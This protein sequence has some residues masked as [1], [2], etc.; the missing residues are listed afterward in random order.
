VS[1]Y[2][3]RG[4]V[5]RTYRLGEADRIVVFLTE[6]HGKARAVAKGVR[7]T[8]SK[9][10]A[11]LEPLTH[12][13]LLLWQGRSDL[14]IVN[15]V[16]V[17]D[18]FRPVREDLARVP[19]G[20]AALEVSDQLAQERHPDP[21][22]YSMLVGAL[23]ALAEQD[24]DPTLLAPSFFLKALVLEGAGPVLEECATC[25]E[26]EDAVDLVAFDL[27]AGGALCRAHRSGRPMSPTALALLRR[28]LGGGLA[29][30]L[31]R[32]V[33]PGADEVAELA[34]EAMEVHLDRRIRAV[35]STASL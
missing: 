30:V 1:L 7:R 15:Q 8:T 33:P 28:I 17:L 34:T 25:G 23:R 20:L 10:G 14:D 9:F 32:P 18:S 2:R 19:S 29:G 26:S 12:V 16:E 22:L 4:V 3:D 5:L 11:R 24:N 31:R 6:R 35:R 13:D 21:R 27:V